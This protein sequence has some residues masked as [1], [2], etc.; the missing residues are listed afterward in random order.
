MKATT[1][2]FR[3]IPAT[4]FKD[5]TIKEKISTR[6]GGVEI[7]LTK[8]GYKEQK[9]TAYQNYLGGGM[10]GSIGNDCTLSEWKED[11]KL[12]HIAD[13]LAQY[14]HSLTNPDDE[15]EGMSFENRQSLPLSAY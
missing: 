13:Q 6:G 2:K 12:Q 10:L 4:K 3:D 7:D 9:M 11:P 15:W 5:R 1:K 14:F 8:F